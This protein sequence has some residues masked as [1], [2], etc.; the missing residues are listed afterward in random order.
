VAAAR[1]LLD[2]IATKAEELGAKLETIELIRLAPKV[3]V[4]VVAGES[5]VTA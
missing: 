2:E 1:R 4:G 5:V 3:V